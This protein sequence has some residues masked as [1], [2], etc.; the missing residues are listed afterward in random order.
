MTRPCAQKGGTT[1]FRLGVPRRRVLAALPVKNRTCKGPMAS[2]GK[3]LHSAATGPPQA[4]LASVCPRGNR[5]LLSTD[6]PSGSR[7][8]SGRSRGLSVTR[9]L[10]PPSTDQALAW[11]ERGPRRERGPST[12]VPLGGHTASAQSLAGPLVQACGAGGDQADA[13]GRSVSLGASEDRLQ[14][15]QEEGVKRQ[16]LH[17]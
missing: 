4:S 15:E 6:V 1:T 9:L 12:G 14:C 16:P 7:W 2:L 17:P 8:G 13:V 3:A 5:G 10:L 11:W